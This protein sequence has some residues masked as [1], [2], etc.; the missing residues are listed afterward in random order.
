MPTTFYRDSEFTYLVLH[1]KPISAND[2]QIL[3]WLLSAE[4]L[5][6]KLIHG[7]MIGP[8][9][10]MITPWS[11]NAVEITQIAGI[12]GID[13]IEKFYVR[14]EDHPHDP[15]LE[16]VY[17]E[18]SA[19]SLTVTKARQ[20]TRA[21]TDIRAYNKEMGL[22]L[23]SEEV[24]YLHGLS[25][26]LGRL[27]NDCEIFGF[28]QVN[29]EHCRHK[30][31]NGE[32]TIDGE[33]KDIS[34]FGLIKKTAKENPG[35]VLSFYNDN[36]A[37]MQGHKG[38]QFAPIHG[39]KPSEFKLKP[40]DAAYT[41]KA[42]TH[43][44]PTTVEP[45]NGAATGSGG[46]IRDRMAGGKGSFPLAGTACYM[47]SY[48]RLQTGF[49]EGRFKPR[50]WLYQTPQ[51][52]LT[53]ASN[54]ASDYG[55]KF[56]QPL[57]NGSLLVFEGQI[58]DDFFAF[59]K[60]VMLAGGVG[61]GHTHDVKKDQPKE[62]DA[63]VLMGGDNYRI[64]MGGGAVSSVDTGAFDRKIELN[65][66]QRSNPEMQKRVF[67]AL[68]ALYE[69]DCN[70]IV[71]IHDHGAGGHVNCLSELIDPVGGEIDLSKLPVG[72]PSLS[73]LELIGNESQERMGL[74]VPMA[75]L[76]LVLAI[77]KRERAPCYHIGNIKGD[78]QLTFKSKD[79][80]TPIHLK[81]SDF[82]GNPPKTLIES[83]SVV[84][85]TQDVPC[86]AQNFRRDLQ[87]VLRLEHVGCKD[88]LTNKVD[89]SVSGRVALQQCTGPYQLPLN[90]AGIM[91]LDYTSTNG[92]AT[93]MGQQPLAGLLSPAIGSQLGLIESLTN[94]IFT[95]LSQGLNGIT[96]SANWMWPCKTPGEDARLYDAVEAASRTAIDLGIC[97]STGKDS[98]SMNQ[99]YPNGQEIRSPGTVIFS[100]V[101]P[102][103]D[104]RKTV[105]PDLKPV[106]RSVLLYINLSGQTEN[107]LG[108]S[109]L[110]QSLGELGVT[111]PSVTDIQGFRTAYTWI[112]KLVSEQKL[113]AGQDISAGGLVTALLEMAFTGGCGVNLSWN[114]TLDAD[115]TSNFLFCEKPGVVLQV[116]EKD[117]EGMIAEAKHLNIDALALGIVL[118]HDPYFTLHA[119]ELSFLDNLSSL[120]R[121]WYSP[122]FCLE[123]YQAEHS[124]ALKRFQ[125]IDK[126]P[127]TYTFPKDFTGIAKLPLNQNRDDA[128]PL[129]VIIREKG[130]N[131]ERE[132]AFSLHAAGF[133]VRDVAMTDLQTGRETLDDVSIAV[134]CGGF[135]NSDVLGS[136]RG[137]AAAFKY[138]DNARTALENFYKR[139]DTL[140]LG[141]CNGC[142]LMVLLE[143]LNISKNIHP[144]MQ[145]NHSKKFESAFLSVSIPENTNAVMLQKL[146]GTTLGI[147]V[148]HGEGRFEL[149]GKED[150][151][152][153]ALTYTGHEYP[154][155]PNGSRYNIA[156]LCSPDGRHL[157][158]MPHLERAIYPWQWGYYPM[159]KKM[160]Q[161]SPWYEAFVS[162]REWVDAK[163]NSKH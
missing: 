116:N 105:T 145:H 9:A 54:G 144:T 121:T 81:L 26:Q 44:F 11:T 103:D 10:E 87:N 62:G 151:Y 39:E 2:K 141:V 79:G 101:S 23:S 58:G 152:E 55:N 47:T 66:V 114:T 67:N 88:W 77:A 162:A 31:F 108:G 19:D 51:E 3:S 33:K 1:S 49:W 102:V 27:L 75:D 115:E 82:F 140:S 76:P 111:P 130:T 59:D 70:P 90:G 155:N 22:A 17:S 100:A 86:K 99:K 57:I 46:E 163:K 68:R 157:A 6:E 124:D 24:E 16:Q 120:R 98:L 73:D 28:A 53:K 40:M 159:D 113:L 69:A 83:K 15:M 94:L 78:K 138:N 158:M 107:L 41:I 48:P 127:L 117:A 92:V 29:S 128:A 12:I 149:A 65:A 89:R 137:W 146:R 74:V 136:A 21:I 133:R 71:L 43:N 119:G 142:Q 34:L 134:F 143:L 63:I 60:T 118:P 13:R 123:K 42:E 32:F 112:Q 85:A 8:R 4:I 131:G 161:V 153:I 148:A 109:A 150:D 64:G 80:S 56:G 104:F 36:V 35:L 84:R 25:K 30:I 126:Y 106:E 93:A 91:A 122:S 45:F 37:F 139:P 160:E 18:L 20:S 97:I 38:Q 147:W 5:K 125:N 96:L 156:G 135:S 61:I 72:D 7:P 154:Q 52:I 110:L 50:N 14:K 132:M 95:P 129:A